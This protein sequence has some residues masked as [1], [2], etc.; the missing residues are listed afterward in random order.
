MK[1]E[2]TDEPKYYVSSDI[3]KRGFCAVCGSRIVWQASRADHRD[4]SG[5]RPLPAVGRDF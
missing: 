5:F 3:G 2:S 1:H 4:V